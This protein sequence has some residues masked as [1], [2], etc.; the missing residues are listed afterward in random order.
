MN[1][2]DEYKK[3]ILEISPNEAALER[4]R[5]GV[6][7]KLAEPETAKKKP[8]PLR[9]IAVIGGS[10]AACLVIGVTAVV[11]TGGGRNLADKMNNLTINAPTA[12]A[13]G[14]SMGGGANA[15]P[16]PDMSSRPNFDDVNGADHTD[17]GGMTN[18]EGVTSND[19][20]GDT[21]GEFSPD[22]SIPVSGAAEQE[23]SS[24]AAR[25]TL[26][27]KTLTLEYNGETTVFRA[28]YNGVGKESEDEFGAKPALSDQ[29]A[30]RIAVIS[31]DGEKMFLELQDDEAVL[32]DIENEFLGIYVKTE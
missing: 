19:G 8:L 1:F 23:P 9:R 16:N 26:D 5:S 29:S 13:S 11:I 12:S 28:R 6:A 15:A 17:Q 14:G 27:G 25:I 22:A 21:V 7:K 31:S 32:F 4:I 10:V 24:S 3:E 2:R 30:E 20:Y 18:T